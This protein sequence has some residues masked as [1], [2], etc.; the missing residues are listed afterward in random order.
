MKTSIKKLL[1]SHFFSILLVF[2]FSFFAGFA[3]LHPGL[4]PTHDGEYH[5]V[6]FYEF[7]KTLRNGNW[8]PRWAPDFYFGYGLPLFNYVYPFP[9]Y[10][11]SF[12]H[13]FGIGFIDGLKLNMFFATILGG[14]FFYVWTKEFWGKLGG[15]VSSVC[16]TFAPYHFVD[17]YIR[18]SVG[19]VWALAFYPAFLYSV[20]QTFKTNKRPYLYLSAIFFACII[21]SHN[22]LALAFFPFVLCYISLFWF[23]SQHKKQIFMQ[24][25]FV[26]LLGFALSAIF[27]LPALSETKFVTGL[28]VYSIENNFPDIAQL[29]MPSW[30]SEF[31]G[32][33]S[34]TEMSVQIGV[35]NLLVILFSFFVLI[36]LLRKHDRNIVYVVSFLVFFFV[37]NFLMLKISLPFWQYVPLMHYFQFPWRL[38]SL[39]ILV[40]AFLAGSV[41]YTF[42][43]VV[44]AGG[45]VVIMILVTLQYTKPSHYLYRTDSYYT[46]RSNFIDGTNSPGN[47]FNTIWAGG[48]GKRAKEKIEI[49]IK[50]GKIL[51]QQISST[52][53]LFSVSL[54]KKTTVT[55]HTLYFPGWKAFVDGKEIAISRN[56]EGISVLN[57]TRGK[58]M[59]EYVLKDTPVRQL[60][61]TISIL[62][63]V[64]VLTQLAKSCYIGNNKNEYSS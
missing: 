41:V 49:P 45:L 50:N 57:L 11:A 54:T 33:G 7:D 59:V 26:F 51:H 38:L 19:E 17:M 13:V 4:P 27:W 8:Y 1:E 63:F 12:L 10:V 64:L 5:V 35:A 37:L 29:L 15:I 21:F 20:T 16:Y 18:G 58:H 6:R 22:I 34:G 30:G 14:I 40:C 43:S 56:D 3:L 28:Q 39:Q 23:L 2:L 60:A 52:R 53:Y 62:S 32:V 47:A 9:N 31:F 44:V 55:I 25:I 61:T 24:V 48:I 46:T 36:R 42:R